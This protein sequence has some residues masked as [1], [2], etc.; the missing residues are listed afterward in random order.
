MDINCYNSYLEVDLGAVRENYRKVQAHVNGRCGI[1]PVVKANSYAMGIERIAAL[2]EDEF[3]VKMLGVAQ[4]Y[5]GVRLRGARIKCGL[6]VM[7]AT[8]ACG[9]KP[10]LEAG[11]TLTVFRPEEIHLVAETA[12]SLGKKSVAVHIKI[13]TGMNRIGANAGDELAALIAAIKACGSVEVSGVFTHFA[14][15]SAYGDANTLAQFELF[16]QAVAQVRHAGFAPEYIHCCN[17]GATVWLD[18]ALDF[19]THVRPGSLILGYDMMEDGSNPLGVREPMSWRAKLTNVRTVMPGEGVGYGRHFKP[20]AP[21]AV[22]TVD[23]GYGD[24]LYRPMV[25]CGGPVYVNDSK[26]CYLACCMDQ[27]FVDVTGIDCKVGDE[28]TIV[29]Y[30]AGG[31]LL[32]AFELEKFTGQCY[33]NA[34]CSINDRVLRVY[35][36]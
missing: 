2:M 25:M 19:C 5:E 18:E 10:A 9:I 20:Q 15:S 13:N 17:S 4:V 28:V 14:T 12:A 32:S 30:T 24:G 26:T 34:L 8:P 11:L 33:Q 7:G 29:G 35:K 3:T 1:I 16:K 36:E 21:T 6:L 23:I 31:Q 27:C 22:G